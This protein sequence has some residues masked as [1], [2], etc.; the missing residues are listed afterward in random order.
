MLHEPRPVGIGTG[1][2]TGAGQ[3]FVEAWVEDEGPGIAAD[4]ASTIFERFQRGAGTEPEAPGLGLGL[5]IV[6]SI[7]ERH[8][9]SVRVERTSAERTRFSMLL[10][11]SQAADVEPAG[12]LT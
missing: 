3:A 4:S 7:I 2:G 11:Q 9:G 8:G 5:W 12:L 6:K 1:I 10:P